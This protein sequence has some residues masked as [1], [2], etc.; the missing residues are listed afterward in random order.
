MQL[1]VAPPP[2]QPAPTE[3]ATPAEAFRKKLGD[4]GTLVV[5][6]RVG[7]RREVRLAE[8]TAAKEE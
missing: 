2:G 8:L 6:D 3:F 7:H 1:F 5:I 4:G